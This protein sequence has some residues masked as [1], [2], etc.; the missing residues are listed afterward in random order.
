MDLKQLRVI[1]SEI[2]HQIKKVFAQYGFNVTH[3]KA[4][5]DP[6]TGQLIWNLKLADINMRDKDG[7]QTSPEAERYRL[8]AQM[9]GLPSDGVGRTFQSYG[10]KTYKI[11]GLRGGRTQKSVVAE[12]DGKRY[13]FDP[14]DV[15]R[16]LA[17]EMTST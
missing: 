4:S 2:D 3:R 16:H 7:N 5:M 13:V 15:K 12:R 8:F 6:D 10:G 17:A 1:S 14:V 11:I 9:Y